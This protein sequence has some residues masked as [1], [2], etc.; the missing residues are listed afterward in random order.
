M[1]ARR[2]FLFSI[3]WLA[4]FQVCFSQEKT[5]AILVDDM[6]AENC[7][8]F[9]ARF[10]GFFSLLQDEPTS[11]GYIIIYGKKGSTSPENLRYEKL[12]DG[13]IRFRNLDRSRLVIIR[14]EERN[15]VQMQKHQTSSKEIG[16]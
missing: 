12:T 13:I 15:D 9:W 7:E 3:I 6:P 4:T 11:I 14:G 1:K 8:S 10:D 5:E 16:I 2:I